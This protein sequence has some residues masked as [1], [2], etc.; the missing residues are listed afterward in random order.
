MKKKKKIP[1]RT[2]TPK[3]VIASPY[4]SKTSL[5]QQKCSNCKHSGSCTYTYRTPVY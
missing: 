3:Q 2:K 4:A 1:W 5:H